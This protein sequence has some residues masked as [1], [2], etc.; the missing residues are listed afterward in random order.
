RNRR[1]LADARPVMSGFP[2]ILWRRRT[3]KGSPR[4]ARRA[5]A[6]PAGPLAQLLLGYWEALRP[7]GRNGFAPCGV[8][9][10]KKEL[11]PMRMSKRFGL[12]A[13]AVAFTASTAAV[14]APTFINVLTG[15]TSGVYYPIGVA[16]S[17]LYGN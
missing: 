3:A 15:G 4:S 6:G 14:A 16:L 12:F 5:C 2:L 11:Q 7:S 9:P 10:I 1:I 17:Q 13:A 8:C